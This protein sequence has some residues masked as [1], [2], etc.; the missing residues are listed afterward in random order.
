MGDFSAFDDNGDSQLFMVGLRPTLPLL[1]N[2]RDYLL[3]E[4]CRPFTVPPFGFIMEV[5]KLEH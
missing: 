2:I 5:W 4:R 1:P 3:I